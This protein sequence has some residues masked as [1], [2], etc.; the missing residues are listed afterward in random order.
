MDE[1]RT[2]IYSVNA[3]VVQ[4]K[5]LKANQHTLTFQAPDIARS[6]AP[7]SFIHLDLGS[8]RHA[9]RRPFSILWRDSEAGTIEILYKV[10][11]QGTEELTHIQEGESRSVLGPI[12]HGFQVAPEHDRPLLVGGG[13]GIPPIL[14]LTREIRHH[15]SPFVVMGSEIPFPF[16]ARPSTVRVPGMP[17]GVIAGMTLLEDYGV[18][19][20]LCSTQ[21]YAGCYEG[22]V[23]ALARRWLDTQAAD[24]R[25]RV[26][27]FACGPMPMLEAIARLAREFSVPC[28]VCV[29]EYMACAVGGCAG[30]TLPVM[31]QGRLAMKRVCVD[32]PVFD[33][34][35]VFYATA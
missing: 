17:D 31:D 6:A 18:A 23:D 28:Q 16:E 2:T 11:G 10:T 1:S 13:V 30:C 20:R 22:Y 26:G 21:G 5:H 34:Q 24:H 8:S 15:T 3:R 27:I 29:E 33:A 14:F 7:G 9:M 12:G 35:S 25:A 32:G 4:V 19:S